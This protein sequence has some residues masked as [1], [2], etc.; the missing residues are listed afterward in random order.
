VSPTAAES[1]VVAVAALVVCH[2]CTPAQNGGVEDA[3]PPSAVVSSD[4][5]VAME[6][7]PCFGTCPVYRVEI[8]ADGAVTFTGERHVD[9]I[10]T[11]SHRIEPDEAAVLM[12]GL[13]AGGFFDLAGNYTHDAEECGMYHTDA[14]RVDLTVRIDGRSKTV[15]H[16]YGCGGAPASLRS[17][18]ERV[19]SVAGVS[20][21]VG[22]R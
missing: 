2:A 5:R 10:G 6:R 22:G 20:R 13:L 11:M 18:Q 12:Q 3:D 4:S 14:P 19:D 7:F 1:V 9:S 15:Q 8:A 21:W 17:F 16:D